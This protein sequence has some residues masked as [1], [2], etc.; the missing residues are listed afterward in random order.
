MKY[1]VEI[2]S[3]DMIYIPSFVNIGS[4]I[5]KLMKGIHRQTAGR[6]HKATSFLPNKI[7]QDY[8][9]VTRIKYRLTN[10]QSFYSKPF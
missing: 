10:I 3:G 1:V 2:G 9:M 8:K 5:Q 6:A 7:K 4:A